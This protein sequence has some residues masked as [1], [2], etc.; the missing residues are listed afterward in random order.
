MKLSAFGEKFSARCGA[1]ELMDDLGNALLENP[2]AI[3]MGG[4]NPGKIPQMEEI[5]QQR[6]QS[7]IDSGDERHQLLGKYQ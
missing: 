1:V 5:F 3:L 6:L 2:D 7:I 4:G